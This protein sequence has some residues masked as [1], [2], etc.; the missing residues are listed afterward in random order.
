[1]GFPM[2]IQ[3]ARTSVI[4]RGKCRR[5]RL[6]Q[7]CTDPYARLW[8]G[9]A[10]D[11]RPY[12]YQVG[13]GGSLFL[14]SVS[15]LVGSKLQGLEIRPTGALLLFEIASRARFGRTPPQIADRRRGEAFDTALRWRLNAH[16]ELKPSRQLNGAW[17]RAL[18]GLEV[19]DLRKTGS[20]YRQVA[21]DIIVR[22]V[23]D[24]GS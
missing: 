9:S 3:I 6:E 11:R 7:P 14:G 23:E 20:A 2:S 5:N 16:S 21:R 10:R 19:A 12:A 24:V 1:M 15:C 8:Q 4:V 17:A 22:M 18:G 13:F